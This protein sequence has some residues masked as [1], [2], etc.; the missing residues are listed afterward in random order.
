MTKRFRV[1]LLFNANKVYDRQIIQGVGE[2]LKAADRDWE[3]FLPEDFT[4]HLE[5]I[6]S[7]NVDGIIADFDDPNIRNKL[8]LTTAY[9][10][11]VGSAFQDLNDYPNAPY[12]ATDN[13]KIIELA[14]EHLKEKGLEQFAFYGQEHGEGNKWA[15][16]R[17][18]AFRSIVEKQG[19]KG[20]LFSGKE[21]THD[22]WQYHM[23]RLLDWLQRLPLPIGIIA[24]TD[25]RARFILQACEKLNLL[26]PDK[27]AVIG[28]DNDEVARSLAKIPLSSVTQ[29]TQQMGYR[30]AA[31]LDKNFRNAQAEVDE[32]S[33]TQQPILVA[34]KSVV[35]RQSTDF[36]PI[37]DRYVIQAMHYIRGNAC[38]GI[39]VEQVLDF[40]GISRSN[41]E[42]RFKRER[43]HSMH[44]E[45]H[46][47]KFNRAC[48]LLKT[49][50]DPIADIA[51]KA[52]YP[53]LQYMYNVFKRDLNQTPKDYRE[54]SSL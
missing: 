19:Y 25:S 12:V 23:N 15:K 51:Q 8:K 29:G 28:V 5:K 42:A 35:A 3:L 14:F 4:T 24:T 31:L 20:Y 49:T 22:N 32:S 45:I 37:M 2:Y 6:S 34:P 13:E 21:I 30:A 48:T 16:E 33:R 1:T 39:K 17:E 50:Q 44:Q 11:G 7:L 43:G 47:V 41:L 18:Q 38:R 53:S 27:V 26:V 40:V 10:V 54:Q 46:Q 9:V 36:H 52:G